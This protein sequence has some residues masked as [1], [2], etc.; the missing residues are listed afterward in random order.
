MKKWTLELDMKKLDRTTIWLSLYRHRSFL[1]LTTNRSSCERVSCQR[2]VFWNLFFELFPET[3]AL[4]EILWQRQLIVTVLPGGVRLSGPFARVMPSRTC[5]SKL[6]KWWSTAPMR[7]RGEWWGRPPSRYH[8]Y[9]GYSH[10]TRST[11]ICPVVLT[12]IL[13]TTVTPGSLR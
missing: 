4:C 2:R 7:P 8:R 6:W 13:T 12:A 3:S 9:P 1:T 5:Y 11:P 10:S